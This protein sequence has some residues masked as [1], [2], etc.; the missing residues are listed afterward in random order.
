MVERRRKMADCENIK[1][2]IGHEILPITSKVEYTGKYYLGTRNMHF[3]FLIIRE[4]V[5]FVATCHSVTHEL[6][7]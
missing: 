5:K 6:S 3:N 2:N 1:K 7:T 4:K